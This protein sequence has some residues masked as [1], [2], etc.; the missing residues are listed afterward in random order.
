MLRNQRVLLC[1]DLC[2]SASCKGVV[3]LLHH[4]MTHTVSAPCGGLEFKHWSLAKG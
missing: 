4:A 2:C 1:S 3:E